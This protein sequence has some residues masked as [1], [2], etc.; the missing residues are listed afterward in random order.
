MEVI[1]KPEALEALRP[2]PEPEF[3]A[4]MAVPMPVLALPRMAV[5][6]AEAELRMPRIAQA[7]ASVELVVP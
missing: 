3:S 1:P 6:E 5:P 7:L 2:T 4:M